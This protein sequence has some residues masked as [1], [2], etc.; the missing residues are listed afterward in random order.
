MGEMMKCRYCREEHDESAFWDRKG[1][2]PSCGMREMSIAMECRMENEN[3]EDSTARLE[4]A[5]KNPSALENAA[6]RLK[7]ALFKSIE[8]DIYKKLGPVGVQTFSNMPS[9]ASALSRERFIGGIDAMKKIM[10]EEQEEERVW[11]N[12]AGIG[13]ESYLECTKPV[14]LKV[15]PYLGYAYIPDERVRNQEESP[16]HDWGDPDDRENPMDITVLQMGMC[17]DRG[18][19]FATYKFWREIETKHGSKRTLCIQVSRD[20]ILWLD[21]PIDL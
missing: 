19:S 21:K 15:S 9:S 18:P 1:S 6:K 20:G 17:S 12:C 11:A 10:R 16:L 3:G 14:P 5:R 7:E 13:T 8:N 2:C 4:M